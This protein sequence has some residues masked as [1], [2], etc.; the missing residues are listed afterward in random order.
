MQ[1]YLKAQAALHPA[2]QPQDM[3][4]C[5]YQAAFGAEH[6]LSDPQRARSYL[7]DELAACAASSDCSLLEALSPDACRVNLA[8]WKALGLTENWLFQC[9]LRSCAPRKDGPERFLVCLQAVDVLAHAGSLPFSDNSWQTAKQA[10][11]ARGL[12]PVHHSDAYRAAERPAYRVID[13]RYAR[14]LRLLSRLDLARQQIIA[15]DGRCA[16]GKTTLAD[17]LTAVCGA[18]VIHMDD[19][20][21]PPELRT[22][23]RLQ[24]PG[25]NVHYERF[26][27]EVLPGLKSGDAF[28]YGKFD[29]SLVALNGQQSI[30]KSSIYM[31]E[32]AYSCHPAL[33]DY[34]TLRAFSDIA[35]AAQQQ[36]ILARNGKAGLE[37]FNARW[38]PMEEKYFAAFGI[39][40]KADIILPAQALPAGM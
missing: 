2:M 1:A 8:A 27:D 33:G 25:G 11:L 26:A 17:D 7:H 38:I 19:F 10:Y 20:F 12:H 32:G 6:L 16:S 15:L 39:R 3:L 34:M 29:C 40:E 22:E 21:L 23:A 13:Q 18:A 28:A 24:T 36:R 31:V 5:C 35:P 30:P 14:L 9:F 37:N 4:K